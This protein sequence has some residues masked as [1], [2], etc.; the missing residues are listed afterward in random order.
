MPDTPLD[1][2]RARRKA[3]GK[4]FRMPRHI[5]E[6]SEGMELTPQQ[7]E[8]D[9]SKGKSEDTIKTT[10]VTGDGAKPK[11]STRR[12]TNETQKES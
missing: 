12:G 4:I 11:T 8:L 6:A 10:T 5:V 7:R 1:V 2:V 3:D 9:K